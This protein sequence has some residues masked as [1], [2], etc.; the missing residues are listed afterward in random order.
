M[1]ESIR[2]N[3]AGRGGRAGGDRRGGRAGRGRRRAR[4]E[5]EGDEAPAEGEAYPEV[6]DDG[7]RPRP[8]GKAREP[9]PRRLRSSAS[10]RSR[11]TCARCSATALLDAGGDAGAGGEVRQDAGLGAPRRARDVEPAARGEDR[12]RVPPRLQ[13]HHGP[14]PGGEH[15]PHAGREALRPVPRREALLVRGVVDPRV[16][17]AVHPEQ[18]APREARDDAGAAKALLQPAKEARRARRRWASIRRTPRSRSSSTSPR[19]TSPRWTCASQS[20]EKSLDAPVGDAEGRATAKVD[21]MPSLVEGPERSMADSELQGLLKEK[22]GDVPR[23]R[24]SARRRTSRSSTSASS[25]TSRSRCRSSATVRDLARAR[26]P[27][28]AAADGPP[29]RVP[30]RRDGRRG[31][32]RV[33]A[34]DDGDARDALPRRDAD[35]QPRRHDGARASRRCAPCDRIVAE[36]TRRTRQLLTHLGIAGKPVDASRRARERARRGARRRAARRGRARSRS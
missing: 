27:A 6:A 12:L 25:P 17:P 13:E 32:S 26:A 19:A 29:A 33:S 24:S 10:I 15:R 36:D 20:S 28:R 7:A 18:L 21:T 34:R 31:R 8:R 35:R 1:P 23:R 5:G 14:H 11:R 30:A 22:L 3:G 9:A 4:A 2:P 16:H